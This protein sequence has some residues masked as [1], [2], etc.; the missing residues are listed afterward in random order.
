M[1]TSTSKRA[2]YCRVLLV[3]DPPAPRS[4]GADQVMATHTTHSAST[5]DDL[6]MIRVSEATTQSSTGPYNA[7]DTDTCPAGEVHATCAAA[8]AA[9]IRAAASDPAGGDAAAATATLGAIDDALI[10]LLT[11]LE[12]LEAARA[13]LHEAMREV[14]R[15]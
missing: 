9:A 3:D 2:N 10:D 14:R 6:I 5:G 8:M 12:E 11:G 1:H 13:E 7:V 15:V 4:Q